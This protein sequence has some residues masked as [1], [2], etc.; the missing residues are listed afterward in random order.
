VSIVSSTYTVGH[1]QRD[2]TRK[3]REIHTDS[4]GRFHT[5]MY[6]APPGTDYDAELA[7]R[8]AALNAELAE[9][10]IEALLNG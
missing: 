8:A 6:W 4:D 3:V 5:R 1:E 2:G 10:E 7:N 9:R